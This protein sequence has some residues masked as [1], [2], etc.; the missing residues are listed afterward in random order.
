VGFS[1]PLG[2]NPTIWPVCSTWM[3]M[4]HFASWGS[5]LHV[6]YACLLAILITYMGTTNNWAEMEYLARVVALCR[7]VFPCVQKSHFGSLCKVEQLK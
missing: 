4:R 1:R 2:K 6:C 7:T 3:A 5:P